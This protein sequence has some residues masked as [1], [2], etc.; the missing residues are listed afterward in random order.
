MQTFWITDIWYGQEL[1]ADKEI[2]KDKLVTVTAVTVS[3][4]PKCQ[5]TVLLIAVPQ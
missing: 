2:L 4:K 5:Q 3:V 1:L